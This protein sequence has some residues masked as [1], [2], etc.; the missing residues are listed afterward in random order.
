LPNTYEGQVGEMK[1][2]PNIT[3]IIESAKIFVKDNF[4]IVLLWL[5]SIGYFFYQIAKKNVDRKFLLINLWVIL[6]PAVSSVVAPNWRHHGRYLIPLIPFINITAINILQKLYEYLDNKNAGRYSLFK[7][8]T[9]VI[10]V[11]VSL[12]STIA[13]SRVL[14]WNVENIN[15]Q[16]VNIGEWLNANL[17]NEKAFG[18]NDIGAITFTTKRY[19]V[20]MAGLVTPEVFS[21]QKMSYED[22]SK[23]LFKFLKSKQVN[24]IIIYPNWF[25][26]IMDNYSK[27]F[28]KVY[29][30]RLENN[31]ICGGI[32]MFVYKIDWDK[33]KTE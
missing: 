18:M 26:Y 17:P 25:D 8:A 9:L 21:F 27:Y 2:L 1:Y 30:A 24:Y 6:L 33:L 32:E 14:G 12:G 20:D 28:E 10:I 13:F 15:D 4:L 23:A 29:S 31:T 16:Q 19:V 5:A 7:K 3:F 11:I 22:G